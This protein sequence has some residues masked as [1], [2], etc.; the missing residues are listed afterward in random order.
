MS[1]TE[2][3]STP[4]AGEAWELQF[5][6][7]PLAEGR[8]RFRVWAPL[9]ESLS[10][11][12]VSEA[13]PQT[14]PLERGED[15]VFEATVPNVG[16]GADYFYVV[17][18]RERPDP[19]SRWQPRGVH[20]PSRV[21]DPDAFAWTDDG[22]TGLPLKDAIIYE[23]HVG[24]FTREGTFE[25]AIKRL[26]H[27]KQL[28]VNAV[29]VMPVAEFPGGRNWGYDGTHSYAP[30]STYGG[31]EGFKRFVDACHREGLAVVLDVV[32]NHLGPE[33]NYLGEFMPLFSKNYRTPWG[34]AL[35]FDGPD[36][37]GVRR[38]FVENALYWLTEYHVDGLRLD[39]IH[40]IIDIGPTH[41]LAEIS[42]AFREQ[43][44]ALGRTAWTIGE[45]D[46][47][48]VRVIEPTCE[49]G[50][51]LDAQWSDDFHHSLHALL[52]GTRR[53][54]FEDFGTVAD[55]AKAV[56]EGFV[57]DGRRS[58]FR[59]KRHGNSSAERRGEDLVVCV[60]N[61]DQ[62]A[63]GYWGDRLASLVSV[64]GQKLA[65]ALLLCAP[66]VPML[67]MGQ[68]WGETAPF[69]YFT[70]HT[71]AALAKAVREGRREEY[72][73]FVKEEGETGS[74]ASDF[75]DPQSVQTFERSKL[76]WSRLDA[77][78][79]AEVLRFYQDLL[80]ARK[81]HAALSNCDKTRTRVEFDE[82]RRW[83]SIERGDADGSRA[84]LLCNLSEQEQEI[85]PARGAW[86]LL[87]WS[88][89]EKY[90]GGSGLTAPP[91]SLG[92]EAARGGVRLSPWNAALYV[93]E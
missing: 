57:Y 6:A 56:S 86:R 55:F 18:G 22:W 52:T 28:G 75:D 15:D 34:D 51:G 50:Y 42:D 16:A 82:T 93:G 25:S 21:V 12:I 76:V 40:R 13:G 60:Q 29:E 38:Y 71:D 81:E 20:G 9:A 66:N 78:P 53:G 63:N 80:A 79:H 24:T 70:S 35:N 1:S 83:I 31:P 17:G 44:R 64:E 72:S 68:E 46:L 65:A 85:P 8:T 10:V 19:V 58:V 48:D 23:L 37:D 7:R 45:S 69:L 84:L 67:F 73:S 43:A 89:G 33:G 88:G 32:Y 27:L 30:Q 61:H 47:N 4:E 5:G 11:K 59:R 3:A 36:S 87:L 74:D 91:S 49:C 90:G 92:D 77:S 14:F 62:I 41:L 2:K 39:A 26:A 54:Y